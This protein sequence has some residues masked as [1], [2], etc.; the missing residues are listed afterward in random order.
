MTVPPPMDPPPVEDCWNRIGIWG[1]ETPRCERLVDLVHCHNCDVFARAGRSLFDRPAP[2]GY[3]EEWA[4]MLALEKEQRQARTLSLVVFR[5]ADE[6][7][8]LPTSVF[9]E[10]TDPRPI[11]R[12]PR[13]RAGGLVAGLVNVRGEIHP[14]VSLAVLL[15]LAAPQAEAAVDRLVLPRIAVVESPSGRWAFRV[16]EVAGLRRVAPEQ[17]RE[18]PSSVSRDRAAFSRALLDGAKGESVALLD[19]LLLFR[20]LDRGVA[21]P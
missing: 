21:E 9:R 2:A 15:G 19:E 8:A 1:D 14:C 13:R 4:R 12:V 3:L 18:V 16:D 6:W 5:V 11:R 20:A 17:L 10:I 7:L